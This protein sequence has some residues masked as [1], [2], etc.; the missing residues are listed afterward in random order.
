MQKPS[1]LKSQSP[2]I[3]TF[4]G[5]N[6][7]VFDTSCHENN[8]SSPFKSTSYSQLLTTDKLCKLKIFLTKIVLYYISDFWT[9]YWLK[10]KKLN[11]SIQERFFP[12]ENKTLVNKQRFWRSQQSYF[13][14]RWEASK[15][16]C[17]MINVS[18]LAWLTSATKW[19]NI[20][21]ASACSSSPF[22]VAVAAAVQ[23]RRRPIAGEAR[24]ARLAWLHGLRLQLG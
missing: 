17:I 7:L 2:K 18:F 5:Q 19:I 24:R 20:P 9:T 16:K 13:E 22:A 8:I 12:Q 23:R 4:F 6:S 1:L 15:R 21:F 10:T 11:R 3:I 14:F